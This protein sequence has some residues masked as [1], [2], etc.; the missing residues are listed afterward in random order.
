MLPQAPSLR[1]LCLSFNKA[2]GLSIL[3]QTQL[4]QKETW[5]QIQTPSQMIEAIQSLKVRGAPLI[6]LSTSLFFA[7]WAHL[8]DV[9]IDKLK[10]VYLQ[11]R[12]ARPTAVNLMNNLDFCWSQFEL[13]QHNKEALLT[14]ALNLFNED[15]FLC[16]QMSL[17]GESLINPGDSLL[18]YCNTGSLATA[19]E[20]TALGV[21]KKAHKNN[22]NISVFA[23]ETRPLG[24]GARLTIW[25]LKKNNIPHTLLCDNMA[26]SLMAQNKISKIFVGADR[27]TKNFDVANKVGTYSLA[28]MAYYHKIPFYVVAPSTS[29]DSQLENGE[30]I[31]IEQRPSSEI[32]DF[33]KLSDTSTYN[34][35]FD[36]TPR[37]LITAIIT[38]SQIIYPNA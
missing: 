32:L 30:Q 17:K 25:E 12:Q 6:G 7:H 29:F 13:N 14:A 38:E 19:G 26:A 18:T 33:W 15:I 36:I 5:I 10:Y 35:G 4:P 2:E 11:L 34:P 23:C 9:S 3:D 24:Q 21:I 22:K 20:G 28:L 1:T 8:N 37:S 16:E 27:I 31:V